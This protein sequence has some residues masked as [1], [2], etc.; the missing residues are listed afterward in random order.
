M[1]TGITGWRRKNTGKSGTRSWRPNVE[2][3]ENRLA[4]AVFHVNT[5][6]DTPAANLT[7]GQDAAGHISLRSAIAAANAHP[8]SNTILLDAG[9]YQASSGAL[10]I[11]SN[12]QII[13]K[14]TDQT[15]LEASHL[16]PIFEAN[17]GNLQ[18]DSLTL[19]GG[20]ADTLIRGNVQFANIHITDAEIVAVTDALFVNKTTTPLPA[21]TVYNLQA[22]FVDVQGF[23]IPTATTSTMVGPIGGGGGTADDEPAQ[24]PETHQTFWRLEATP[25]LQAPAQETPDNSNQPD[26]RGPETSSDTGNFEDEFDWWF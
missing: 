6:M 9:V 2:Q 17:G 26:A 19:T 4:P 16:T 22:N 10:A 1:W 8:Q 3:L 13:G 14:G 11:Q 5:F 24:S 15:V 25:T 7:T 12:L 21:I 23:N 18:L 20:S